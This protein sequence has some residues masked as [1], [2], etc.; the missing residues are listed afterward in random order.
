MLEK[1]P[2]KFLRVKILFEIKITKANKKLFYHF[3]RINNFARLR[4][5]NCFAGHDFLH[6]WAVFNYFLYFS[7]RQIFCVFAQF[8]TVKMCNKNKATNKELAIG[9]KDAKKWILSSNRKFLRVHSNF[10]SIP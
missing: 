8:M 10:L 9:A 4:R 2:A 5:K 6:F 3:C 1:W 7:L